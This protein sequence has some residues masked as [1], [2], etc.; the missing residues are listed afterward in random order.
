MI[1][2]TLLNGAAVIVGSSIG[3]VCSKQLPKRLVE[4]I[5][6]GIGLCTLF[7]GIS[8]S[9]RSENLVLVFFSIVLGTLLGELMQF[10][11]WIQRFSDFLRRYVAKKNERFS[12]GL[13]SSF[14]L[15]C[16]GSLTI[17]G[18]I[19]EGLGRGMTILLTK[20]LLD[21]F[22]AIILAVRLGN[23]VLFSAIPLMI[24][25]GSI[26]L[27][28]GTLEPYVTDTF[29][30]EISAVGGI[31]LIGLGINILEI[32]TIRISNMLLS[33]FVFVAL[34]AIF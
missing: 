13:I 26:A 20:S 28:A 15:F 8:M 27:L 4:S 7:L 31:L 24:V 23:G 10:D 16:I 21:G 34:F 11:R 32:K 25:Q 12:E 17:L 29:I 19:E 9:L 22:A 3:L 5:F 14:F 1:W 33:L 18:P 6:H 30:Q 2:G